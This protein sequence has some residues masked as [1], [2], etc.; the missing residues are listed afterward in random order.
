M[1]SS[2]FHHIAALGMLIKHWPLVKE[3]CN[4][5]CVIRYLIWHYVSTQIL[6]KHLT[7]N[8]LKPA[9]LIFHLKPASLIASPSQ[10]G[11]FLRLIPLEPSL[12][13]LFLSYPICEAN[14]VGSTFKRYP[15]S[16]WF[17]HL[18]C[19]ICGANPCFFSGLLQQPWNWFPGFKPKVL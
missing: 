3:R 14:P 6:N 15:E 10:M 7:L 1:I 13:P 16:D 2:Q 18:L 17:H 12:F 11:T 8:M 9:L 4:I 5:G 19:Y